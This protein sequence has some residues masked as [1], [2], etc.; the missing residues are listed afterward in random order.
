MSLQTDPAR[1]ID[2]TSS[3]ANTEIRLRGLKSLV[4]HGKLQS[5]SFSSLAG[6]LSLS[7]TPINVAFAIGAFAGLRT[8]EI[9]G[10]SSRDV[11]LS[12]ERIHIGGVRLRSGG[13]GLVF[14]PAVAARGGRIGAPP[15]FMRLHTLH[16]HL[17]R[18]L[19]ACGLSR[20][21]W[22]QATR[23]T[24]ASQWILGGGSI[25]KL[26]GLMG[27]GSVVVTERYAHLKVD[28]FK[29]RDFD[30]LDVDLMAD[31]EVIPF[32]QEAGVA[33]TVGYAVVTGGSLASEGQPINTRKNW[34]SPG[35]SVGRAED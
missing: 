1:L 27:H 20:L 31:A 32:A 5:I 28:L 26:K 23:H 3:G 33:G 2:K 15:T 30:M 10:L 18:A 8:A 7:R 16:K 12:T 14:P 25:E 9:L 19:A 35:S 4:D 6:W 21:T 29:S 34:I 13:E 11:N 22:Y 17:R 24:F